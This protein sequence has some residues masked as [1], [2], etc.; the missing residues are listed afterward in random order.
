MKKNKIV[1]L[2]AIAVIVIAII[3]VVIYAVTEDPAV[4]T[5]DRDSKGQFIKFELDHN[6][7]SAKYKYYGY[8]YTISIKDATTG[9]FLPLRK[10]NYDTQYFMTNNDF[11]PIVS[12]SKEKVKI[13]IETVYDILGIDEEYYWHNKLQVY[14]NARMGIRVNDTLT[15]LYDTFD[16]EARSGLIY[17]PSGTYTPN[18]GHGSNVILN[19]DGKG[20]LNG[21]EYEYGTSWSDTTQKNMIKHFGINFPVDAVYKWDRYKMRY[22]DKATGKAIYQETK[23]QSLKEI[24]PIDIYPESVSGYDY[25]GEYK[26]EILDEND[27]VISSKTLNGDSARITL[28][29]ESKK[30]IITFYYN[31]SGTGGDDNTSNITIEYRKDNAEGEELLP[32]K[33][34]TTT[35]NKITINSEKIDDMK[36]IGHWVIFPDGTMVFREETSAT[37]DLNN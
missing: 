14:L 34:I 7:T 6:I 35:Q 17:I 27:K 24:K 21:I 22:I 25:T 28:K 15:R 32:K 37:I 30:N 5:S 8:G 13:Y 12:G 23:Y 9:E 16:G 11:K 26:H 31:S 2:S 33:N 20:I 29:Q 19:K 4:P 18:E 10:A 1:I 3:G 36:C